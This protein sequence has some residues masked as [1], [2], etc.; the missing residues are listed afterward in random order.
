MRVQD[1][2]G[3]ISWTAADK[4][5]FV[6][7]GFVALIQMRALSPEEYGLYQLLVSMQT[8]IFILSDG[9]ALQSVIQFGADREKRPGVNAVA[10]LLSAAIVLGLSLITAL[11]HQPL[12]DLFHAPRFNAVALWLPFYC[13]LTIP[14]AY[15]IKILLRDTQ[16]KQVFWV[17]FF[18]FASMSIMTF[19]MLAQHTL[20]SFDDL[21]IV[22]FAGM[23]LSSLVA[24][25]LSRKLLRFSLKNAPSVRGFLQF[26][27]I[28]L[29]IGAITNA[30]RQLDV[31][32]LQVLFH[33]LFI[34]GIYTAAKTLYRVF[35]TGM[36]ALFS[37]LY[38]SAIRLLP[39]GRRD[40][41]NVLMSKA[42]SYLFLT[43]LA[44]VLVLE[45]GMSGVIIQILG[46]KYVNAVGQFNTLAI[47]ALFV[48]F[49][50]LSAALLALNKNAVLLRYVIVASLCG[51]A[52]FGL[53]S[54]LNMSS[55]FPLGV[56]A[57]SSSLAVMLIVS[58]YRELGISPLAYLRAGP[59]A[60][61][62]VKQRLSKS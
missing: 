7:Y 57:Y 58:V 45:A 19:W 13:L 34:V 30:I 18:W 39:Q 5:L 16:M 29:S 28:Q 22:T 51:L 31:L 1:Y 8:W 35:E 3:K 46:G 9:A 32:V 59:D 37:L 49:Y 55:I 52:V 62:F 38:P 44:I 11:L 24:I 17:N 47:A 54:F 33:D 56:V 14:R 50:P 41:F 36:D 21:I 40:E 60:L 53:S 25:I 26:G 2:V 4:I 43:Y 61:Q 27:S 10:L 6:I 48:P 12:A 15:C 20:R 23:A 42:V